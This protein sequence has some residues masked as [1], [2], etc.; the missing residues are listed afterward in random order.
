MAPFFGPILALIM[1]FHTTKAF[2]STFHFSFP[3][4]PLDLGIRHIHTPESFAISHRLTMPDFELMEV[5]EPWRS[6]NY[7]VVSFKFR[8]LLGE[9]TARMF[10]NERNTSYILISSPNHPENKVL[11]TLTVKKEGMF[12]HKLCVSSMFLNSQQ[13]TPPS[14]MDMISGFGPSILTQE[15][16]DDA[17]RQGYTVRM[18]DPNLL[19][20]RRMVLFAGN[21]LD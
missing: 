16:V 17:I 18:E 8:T 9:N 15:S 5:S 1:Q 4:I 13:I 21:S 14:P 19:T 11:T 10:S 6:G 20:Y 2:S 3:N 7:A 12:G